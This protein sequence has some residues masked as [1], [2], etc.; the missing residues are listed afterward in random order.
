[1][2]ILETSGVSF[3]TFLFSGAAL[4]WWEGYERRRP[5]GA[6][7]LSWQQFSILFLE[8]FVPESRREELRRQFEQ[9]RKGDMSVTQY[10]MWFSELARHA[11]WLVPTDRERIMRFI[12]S[13][14]FQPRLLMTR[15]RVSGATFDE[16]VDIA[17]QIEIVRGQERAEREDKRPHGQGGF[18]GA[19]Q[20]GNSFGHQEQQFRQRRGCFECRD[21]GHI[22]RYFPRLLGGTP[23]RST[24][25]TA[26]A[27][28]PSQPAQPARGGVQPARG[29]AQSA[30]GRPKG[31]GKSGGGQARFYDLS[32]RPDAIALDDVIS[33]C[34]TSWS[35]TTFS[36]GPW[37]DPEE[38]GRFCPLT[39]CALLASTGE[40]NLLSL[41]NHSIIFD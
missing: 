23:Q 26:P 7:P 34:K 1:M 36:I 31:G 28:V 5:V 32:A 4:N 29:G 19:P 3:T 25:P 8:K 10:E 11:V 27:P 40:E 41:I 15:E 6:A 20:G 12:D 39:A 30:M 33:I 13:L 38:Y 14:D 35:L 24:R 16:V 17:R 18:S 22:A 2:G 21:F 9:L 37:V